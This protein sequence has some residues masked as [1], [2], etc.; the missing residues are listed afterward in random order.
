M[1]RRTILKSLTGLLA[2][3]FLKGKAE[4]G[5]LVKQPRIK[6]MHGGSHVG[7][8]IPWDDPAD[9]R[10][11]GVGEECSVTA[12]ADRPLVNMPLIS[13]KHHWRRTFSSRFNDGLLLADY[14]VESGPAFRSMLDPKM[15]VVPPQL[16][17]CTMNLL[18][19]D[20]EGLV[21]G[22]PRTRSAPT[23]RGYEQIEITEM[24]KALPDDK[25]NYLHGRL[26]E[27]TT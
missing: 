10:V 4:A 24:L 14:V 17:V 6:A 8:S 15:S 3:P 18:R 5:E 20:R 19:D 11:Y 22:S 13:V 1:N 21:K 9:V 25:I 12:T 2:L 16:M 7:K 26:K 23:Q 27:L